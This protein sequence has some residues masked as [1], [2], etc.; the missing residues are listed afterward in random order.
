MRDYLP[1]LAMIV[2]V[3]AVRVAVVRRLEA[4]RAEATDLGEAGAVRVRHRARVRAGRALPGEVLPGRDERSSSSTSRSSSSIRSR[5]CSA[6]SARYGLVVD[7]RVPARAARA[8]RLPAVGRRARLGSGASRSSSRIVRSACCAPSACRTRRPRPTRERRRRRTSPEGRVDGP[9]AG[10][11][12]LP[13]RRARGPRA[14]G[15]PQLGV[16]R[17]RS[18]SRAARSR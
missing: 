1:I 10:P 13:H 15:P 3:V 17:R 4:A 16:A 9:R 6:V 5:P 18:V 11:A 7:G 2:L 8:V 14:L 12:Q